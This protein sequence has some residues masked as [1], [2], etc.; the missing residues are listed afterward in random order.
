[1]NTHRQKF[2]LAIT[3]G[4]LALAP[5]QTA[6]AQAVG[7]TSVSIDFPNIIILHYFDSLALTFTDT[8]SYQEN[9]G[10]SQVAAAIVPPS[11]APATTSLG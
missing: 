6:Q 4:L 10:S 2:L 1:M 5:W 8:G 3:L 9:Q 11:A 7:S